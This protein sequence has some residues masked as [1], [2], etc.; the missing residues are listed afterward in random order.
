MALIDAENNDAA[1]LAMED[2]AILAADS[3]PKLVTDGTVSA[4]PGTALADLI[5]SLN[6]DTTDVHST[7]AG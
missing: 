5:E 6:A 4:P 3:P 1:I 7:P 2:A